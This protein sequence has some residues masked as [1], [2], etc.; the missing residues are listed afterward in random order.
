VNV[1]AAFGVHV[2][3]VA[4]AALETNGAEVT[5]SEAGRKANSRTAMIREA[6][7]LD[8]DRDFIEGPRSIKRII[9]V[10][11]SIEHIE[12]KAIAQNSVW[13]TYFYFTL[14]LC[15]KICEESKQ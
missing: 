7:I 8:I 5:P 12:E 9:N 14:F 11:R 1:L 13:H 10:S 15:P 6:K 3:G 2:W 4:A